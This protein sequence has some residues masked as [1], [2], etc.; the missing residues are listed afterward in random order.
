MGIFEEL[1]LYL[2]HSMLKIYNFKVGGK[3]SSLT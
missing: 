1:P 3:Y 2:T